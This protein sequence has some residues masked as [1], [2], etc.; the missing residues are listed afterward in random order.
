M[1]FVRRAPQG[2]CGLKHRAFERRQSAHDGRAPQGAC[3]L[4]HEYVAGTC[5]LSASRPARGV[6]IETVEVA[7]DH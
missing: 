3:G 6:W 1:D 2:A 5:V 7:I 4:K